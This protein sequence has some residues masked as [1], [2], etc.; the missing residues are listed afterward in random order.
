MICEII[1]DYTKV[2]N[3]LSYGIDA[4]DEKQRLKS[5][6]YIKNKLETVATCAT[7]ECIACGA[8]LEEK[9]YSCSPVEII[10]LG[11]NNLMAQLTNFSY[12]YN[13]TTDMFQLRFDFNV[14]YTNPS[15]ITL[16]F[17]DISLDTVI[18]SIT[19]VSTAHPSGSIYRIYGS[20]P[21]DGTDMYARIRITDGATNIDFP[22]QVIL[23]P[24]K[25]TYPCLTGI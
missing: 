12:C 17:I 5:L 11:P 25:D 7:S 23:V 18:Q 10:S 20:I 9:T 15:T 13:D 14:T 2:Y 3:K 21:N 1:N 16:S 22:K 4:C 6:E 8:S 19:S 24:D